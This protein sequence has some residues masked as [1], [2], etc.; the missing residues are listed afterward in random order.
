MFSLF[1]FTAYIEYK[2]TVESDIQTLK[3][4]LNVT[5]TNLESNISSKI[6]AINGLK[7]YVELDKT[8]NQEEY[9]NFAKAVYESSNDIVRNIT[10]ITDTTILHVYPYEESEN[11]IGLNLAK[12]Q[13][14]K[15]LILYAKENNKTII[16]S[17]VD[18]VEGFL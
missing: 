6:V 5:K 9:E 12:Q 1:A 14:Q 3:D 15:D 4:K 18:L 16:T 7:T 8:F 13:E 10:F 11:I 2:R 17:P